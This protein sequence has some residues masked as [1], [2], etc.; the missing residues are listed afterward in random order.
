[1]VPIH[2]ARDFTQGLL[3]TLQR[4]LPLVPLILVN[5]ASKDRELHEWLR[6]YTLD[7]LLADQEVLL[8]EN[9]RQ[10]LFTRTVNRGWR[11]A[12]RLYNPDYLVT[13]N[14]DCRL[15]EGW[16]GKL[17][18]LLDQ[19]PRVGLVGY[20]QHPTGNKPYYPEKL[21]PEYITGHC[22]AA[23][24]SMLDQIGILTETD[25]TGRDS[26]ELAP[27]LGQAHIGSDRLLSWR[28]NAAGWRTYECQHALC[29]HAEGKSW[30]HDLY[31]LHKFQLDPLWDPCDTLDEPVWK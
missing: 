11:A 12:Y 17:T 16:L 5:D 18:D 20:A 22:F 8:L 27:Y 4:T 15:K 25:L 23:R 3:R 10:Q 2:D 28:A 30:K 19:S 1:V 26:R 21:N 6:Q 13:I 9:A 31:W 14:T 24:V 7:R 29:D